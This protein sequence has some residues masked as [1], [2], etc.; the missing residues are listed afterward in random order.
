MKQLTA[1]LIIVVVAGVVGLGWLVNAI[2]DNVDWNTNHAGDELSAYQQLG[3]DLAA[4]LDNLREKDAFLQQWQMH[5]ELTIT[6][7][8]RANFPIPQSLDVNFSQGEPL[9]LESEGAL[10][11]HFYLRESQQVM[12]LLLPN[13]TNETPPLTLSLFL[14]LIFY[15]GV[16]MVVLLWLYPLIRRLILLRN[17]ART[18]GQGDLSAR[19]VGGRISYIADIEREFNRMAER[20]QTLVS[21]NKLLS[22]AVSHDLKTPLARLRFGLDTLAE[23][24]KPASRDK[25]TERISKDLFEMESLVET[26]LQYARLDE[27]NIQ[28]DRTNIDFA[29]FVETLMEKYQ[30]EFDDFSHIKIQYSPLTQHTPLFICADKRYL[31]M[32]LNNIIN[33]AVRYAHSKVG[34]TLTTRAERVCIMVEDDGPGIPPD[35][36]DHVIKPFWRGKNKLATYNGHGMGLAIVQRIAEWLEAEIIIGESVAFG[37]ASVCLSYR[38][39]EK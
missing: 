38:S 30:S 26:L 4:T 7:Q 37:G 9:I 22:R 23:T 14:T 31:T 17:A 33:N 29:L 16:I 27:S 32:Q 1:S 11:L 21:D 6:L 12:S 15:I 2:Y 39:V 20:I 24:D 28:L 3:R 25:Y 8:A 36:R 10:S 13:D 34:V 19:V 18:L 5:S 35:E